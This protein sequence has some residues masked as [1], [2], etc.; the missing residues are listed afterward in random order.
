MSS[1][2]L[3]AKRNHHFV[4][5]YYMKKWSTN[6]RD[7]YFTTKNKTIVFDSVRNVAVAQDFY[8]VGKLT[9]T[10]LEVIKGFLGDADEDLK[11][12]HMSYLSDFI[13]FNR[14]E[15][16]VDS[17]NI[18]D[19]EVEQEL[20][21]FKSNGIENLHTAH[22]NEVKHILDRL[23]EGDL[24]VLED[25]DRMMNFLIF[26]A[27]QMTRTKTMKDNAFL[28]KAKEDSVEG[29]YARI[30]QESWWFVS[31]MLGLNVG[32]S[33][34]LDRKSDN[35]CLLINNTDIPFITSDQPVINAYR[36]T[37]DIVKPP[38]E[39]ECDHYFPL[40]PKVAYM[41][42]KSDRFPSGKVSV[43]EDVI[44]EMNTKIAKLANVNIIS[45]SEGSLKPYRKYVGSWNQKIREQLGS[46]T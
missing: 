40:S 4:W 21:A 22:E 18:L 13:I 5:A 34:Y 37:H 1:K 35:H 31:Y 11:R 9:K 39:H 32:R 15:G 20:K 33:L 3:Q 6:N 42:N 46:D 45:N 7:I 8:Q 26:Y 25:K 12:L 24:S 16:Y 28:Y 36:K 2:R 29:R 38:E 23:I 27:H 14:I 44:E 43:T 30:L 10:H 41:I 19:D 17:N